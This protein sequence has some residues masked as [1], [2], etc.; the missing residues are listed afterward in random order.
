MKYEEFLFWLM[1]ICMIANGVAMGLMMGDGYFF[2][3]FFH[4]SLMMFCLGMIMYYL[5]QVEG[6]D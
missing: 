6:D 3:A 2:M 1:E 4:L 5:N